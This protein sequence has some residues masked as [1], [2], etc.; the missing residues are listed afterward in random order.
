MVSVEAVP[1][2]TS[3]SFLCLVFLSSSH[4][5]LCRLGKTTMVPSQP[6]ENIS[7]FKVFPS[8]DVHIQSLIWSSS[9]VRLS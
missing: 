6:E 8:D 3:P 9:Y 1:F 2:A 4:M 5:L 7:S